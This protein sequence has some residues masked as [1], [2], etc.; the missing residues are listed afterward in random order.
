MFK[1]LHQIFNPKNKDL[2]KRILFTL[3]GLFIFAVGTTIT[4]PGTKGIIS[5]LGFL[6]LINVMSGGALKKF[7]IFGLGVMHVS[8]RLVFK[9]DWS[10][11]SGLGN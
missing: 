1:T 7:S 9:F 10:N 2:R 3:F 4:V 11:V 6:E 5:D 8:F